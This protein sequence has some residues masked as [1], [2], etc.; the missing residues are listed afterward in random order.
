MRSTRKCRKYW[1]LAATALDAGHSGSGLPMR[2]NGETRRRQCI[3]ENGIGIRTFS[4]LHAPIF[5]TYT[6]P[7]L[8]QQHCR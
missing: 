6:G 5:V 7:A 3:R 8:R 1:L 2:G 4:Y